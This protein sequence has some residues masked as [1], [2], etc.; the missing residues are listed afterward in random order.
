MFP[1][2]V[3][4]F[5][6]DHSHASDEDL[7]VYAARRKSLHPTTFDPNSAEKV[8]KVSDYMSTGSVL[9]EM[10][11]LTGMASDVVVTCD[12]SVQVTNKRAY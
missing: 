7:A 12:T 6:L 3:D 5:L 11:L 2:Q 4:K 9:G 10:S 1:P 8:E